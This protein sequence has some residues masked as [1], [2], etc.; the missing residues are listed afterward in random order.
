MLASVTKNRIKN[1]SYVDLEFTLRLERA[2]GSLKLRRSIELDF[3]AK[4]RR[5]KAVKLI[6]IS[7]E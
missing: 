3:A 5:H 4:K 2:A 7:F 6:T 1:E